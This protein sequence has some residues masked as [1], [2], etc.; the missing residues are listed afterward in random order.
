[1]VCQEGHLNFFATSE[2]AAMVTYCINLCEMGCCLD[3]T[4][5]KATAI[6]LARRNHKDIPIMLE[7]YPV[8]SWVS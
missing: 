5:L 7:F 1:M 6:Q 8:N 3:K 4:M 2:E